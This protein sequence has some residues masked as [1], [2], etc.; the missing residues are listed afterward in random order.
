MRR[1][2][3]KAA[4]V[5][6]AVVGTISA[7]LPA[8]C[9]RSKINKEKKPTTTASLLAYCIR[10]KTNREKKPSPSTS[11]T[12]GGR[13]KLE[14]KHMREVGKYFCNYGDFANA[15]L[16]SKKYRYLMEGYKFNPIPSS[17][18]KESL[19]IFKNINTFKFYSS[20]RAT[21]VMI[22]DQNFKNIK[23]IIFEPSSVGFGTFKSILKSNGIN[24]KEKVWKKEIFPLGDGNL[25]DTGSCPEGFKLVL[26]NKR[27]GKQMIFLFEYGSISLVSSQLK[28]DFSREREY[29]NNFVSF[30]SGLNPENPSRMRLEKVNI[31]STKKAVISLKAENIDK[32]SFKGCDNLKFVEVVN[33]IF[34]VEVNAFGFCGDLEKIIFR[35]RVCGL[36]KHVFINCT[37]LKEIEFHNNVFYIGEGCFKGC[38]KLKK[39]NIPESLEVIYWNAFEG[40]PP[41][42]KISYFG[43]EY[44]KDGFFKAFVAHGGF[45]DGRL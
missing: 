37:V 3:R 17:K 43:K 22:S 9:T 4:A 7:S 27:N 20:Q 41:D 23:K 13:G 21:G 26:T 2:L 18:I 40:T 38:R 8:Y 28:Y 11:S 25:N 10:N 32:F 24:A 36:E 5:I 31:S 14:N 16:T 6:L 45:I 30:V 42:L 1:K 39:I 33:D 19:M 29:Y 44:D 34:S 15:I 12:G 35:G